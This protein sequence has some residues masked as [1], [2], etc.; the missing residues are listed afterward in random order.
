MESE[1]VKAHIPCPHCGSKDNACEYTDHYYCFGCEKRWSKSEEESSTA[2]QTYVDR[3]PV[4]GRGS[5]RDLPDRCLTESTCKKFGVSSL[6]TAEGIVEH[7]YPYYNKEGK[8]TAL[9]TRKTQTKEFSWEGDSRECMLFG[10]QLFPKGG[11][12]VTI[13][14]GECFKGDTEVLTP[15]G[16]VKLESLK[17]EKVLQVDDKGCSTF[18]TPI[19]K[20]QKPYKGVLL[21][22]KQ[23]NYSICATE[24]HNIVY[25]YKGKEHKKPFK[26]VP[27]YYHI[28]L[29]THLKDVEST[30]SDDELRLIVAISADGTIDTRKDGRKYV[31]ISFK[32]QRKMERLEGLLKQLRISYHKGVHSSGHTCFCFN[33]QK[34]CKEFS[35]DLLSTIDERQRL[36]F[37]KE[38][39]YWD[40]HTPAEREQTEYYTNLIHNAEFVK[41]VAHISGLYAGI[42]TRKYEGA[43]YADGYTVRVCFNRQRSFANIQQRPLKETFEGL[44][45]CVQVPSGKILIRNRGAISVCGNC[46]CLS[47]YQIFGGTGAYV[48]VKNGAKDIRTIKENYEWLDSFENIIICLDGDTAGREAAIRMAEILPPKKT[49]IVKLSEECKDVNEFLKNRKGEE[50]RKLWWNAEEYRPEDIVN[51]TSLLDRVMDYRK[52]HQYMPTPWEGLNE[53]LQGT[54]AGQLAILTSGSGCVD[55]DTEFFTGKGWKKIC[56][57]VEGDKV[58]QFDTSSE[59]ASLVK[60]LKFIKEPCTDMYHFTTKYGLDMMLSS[61][62][63]ILYKNDKGSYMKATAE[64]IVKRY[65]ENST[66]FKGLIP[67]TF[68]YTGE[69]FPLSDIEIKIMLA[70][71]ADGSF[72]EGCLR[73]FFHLKK[74]RKKEEL[75]SLL[76]EYGIHWN[77]YKR[78]DGY[79]DISFRSPR[80]EKTFSEDWYKCN[81]KQLQLICDNVL[82][83][84]GKVD[85]IGRRTFYTTSKE[86]ADFIQFAFSACGYRA[87]IKEQDRRGRIRVL[88]G[89]EYATK[90]VDYI[91]SITDRNLCSLS[92]PT[93]D[94]RNVKEVKTAD[95]FKYCFTVP[96][97]NLVLRRNGCVFIT[98]NSGK[99]LFLRTWMLHL[100][101]TYTDLNVG[102]LFMEESVEET[103]VSL[104]STVAGKNLKKPAVWEECSKEELTEYFY[105]ASHNGRIELFEPKEQTTPSY[106]ANKIRY[107]A[108]AKG[109]KVI[110]LDHLTFLV[111]TSDDI[112]KDLNRLSKDIKEMCVALD[113][114]VIAAIHLRKS[115]SGKD[116]E[117]GAV[118]RLDDIK[119]S[120]SVK[121]L[122]DIVIALERDGQNEDR[123]KANTTTMRVLKNRDFGAKGVACGLLYDSETTRLQEIP[124]D[125]LLSDD[126]VF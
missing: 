7:Y 46:D 45:Y 17:D 65:R 57:Y 72:S 94:K 29:T 122:S 2:R 1:Q 108:M 86:S 76:N 55:K 95:G 68:K 43:K 27:W 11:R 84:D 47:A 93:G 30:V 101:K 115:Q 123:V 126:S 31:R 92:N 85:D 40:G 61:C 54:R 23:K 87:R 118:V 20:I 109:C 59:T 6:K 19:C 73:C 99:S 25:Y 24:G 66:G 104:M 18:V 62:H 34:A 41:T 91:V 63:N 83:W 64:E 32:K 78:K 9:K 22:H 116:H 21:S 82:K 110:F 35:Y 111:D 98:G 74:E 26:D 12:Y 71:I 124:A 37:L 8:F 81:Q 67:T 77:E 102:G 42:S 60:P 49:K 16:W 96:S 120:S 44:V 5:F 70:V 121:Q 107:L 53:M 48:S 90:S 38:L 56:D 79:S 106:I 112:R 105:E 103:V 33:F 39:S 119:D 50:F 51:V 52:T 113:I 4:V 10:Q 58:L 14:E 28:P 13:C 100:M 3:K 88:N 36:L 114:T 117:S 15:T 69:G 80:R 97:N 75:R 125:I 89:K